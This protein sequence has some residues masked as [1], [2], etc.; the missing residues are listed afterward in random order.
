MKGCDR[1]LS[2]VAN[3]A[4]KQLA[5]RNAHERGPSDKGLLNLAKGVEGNE[6]E[7]HPRGSPRGRGV[8]VVEMFSGREGR[9]RTE[10]LFPERRRMTGCPAIWLCNPPTR[11]RPGRH[12]TSRKPRRRCRQFLG[13]LWVLREPKR[14]TNY[15]GEV[16]PLSKIEGGPI[17]SAYLQASG[18][19]A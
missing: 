18:G 4:G 8:N 3:R 9:G 6:V 7:T 15:G 11:Q 16:A 2:G 1:R 5:V 19:K 14:A 13:A 12:C 17:V 10:N